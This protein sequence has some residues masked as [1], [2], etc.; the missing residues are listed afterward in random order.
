MKPVRPP[1]LALALLERWV[2]DHEALTGD[3]VEEFQVRR[4]RRWLWGQVVVAL[5]VAARHRPQEI[6]P[7]RLVDRPSRFADTDPRSR[8]RPVNLT[9]SPLDG[10][11]GL[12]LVLLVTLVSV[13]RPET[14]WIVLAAMASGVV[15][16]LA[17]IA[18]S[19]HRLRLPASNGSASLRISGG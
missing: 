16:G 15:L 1:R 9:G 19:R 8:L 13:L 3:L 14:W 2:P 18:I 10:I 7:L 17:R 12:G 11:G 4:S 5:F 6:R